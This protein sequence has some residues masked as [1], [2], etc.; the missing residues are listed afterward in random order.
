MARIALACDPPAARNLAA[1][2]LSQFVTSRA[3]WHASFRDG[4]KSM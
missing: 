4:A 2:P 3:R 1:R